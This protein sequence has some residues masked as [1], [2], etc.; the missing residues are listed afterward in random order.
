VKLLWSKNILF[1]SLS[2]EILMLQTS[3]FARPT[4]LAPVLDA[5]L[6]FFVVVLHGRASDL[7][8]KGSAKA[9]K[10]LLNTWVCSADA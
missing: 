10:G 9:D 4:L 6:G 1:R 2:P 7:G 3:R 8:D 5:G